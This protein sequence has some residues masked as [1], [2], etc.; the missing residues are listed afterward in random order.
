MDKLDKVKELLK[1]TE[2]EDLDVSGETA[3]EVI[4]YLEERINE[5]EVI[6]YSNAMK[7]LSENDASLNESLA[8]ANELGYEV[9]NINSELLATLL[10]QQNMRNALSKIQSEIEDIFEEEA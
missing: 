4:E 6:Y 10:Q 9:K 8:I 3:E 1:Y 7:Y 2:L 5:E